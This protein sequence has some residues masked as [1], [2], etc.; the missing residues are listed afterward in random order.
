MELEHVFNGRYRVDSRLGTGGMAIVYC[1]TDL[2]LRRR[3]AIKVLRDQFSADDD[4]IKRFSY[5]AQAAAR[6]SHPNV[7][8]VYDFGH[9]GDAYF[10]VMELVEGE[11]LA[12]MLRGERRIPESVAIDYAT[13]IAAGLAFAHRQGLLHRDV[14]PAN[15][16]VTGDDV[17]KLGDF[18]IARAVAENAIGVTQPGMVMGSVAYVSPEQAQGRE[19]DARSD[20]YSLGVVLYQ[21]VTGR[22]P[23]NGETPVAVAL[24]HVSEAAPALDPA[25]DGV[26]PALASIVATLLQKNPDDRFASATELSSALREAREQPAVTLGTAGRG[27]GDAPTSRF[28][29]VTPPPAP[30]PRQSAAPDR[31]PSNGVAAF[32][33]PMPPAFDRRWIPF[34]ALMLIV[35]G[36]VGYLGARAL[37]PRKDIPVA[38]FVNN[39]SMQAQQSLVGDGLRPDVRTEA[40]ETVPLDRVIR[41]DPPVGS[42]TSR[43]ATVV[44]FV[45]SG[46]PLVPIPD[47]KGFTAADAQHMLAGTKF[48]T[49]IEGRFDATAAKDTV[50]DVSPAAGT[51]AAEGSTITLTVSQ[52][53]QPVRVPQLVGAA[54]DA[55]RA[56]LAPLGLKLNVDQQTPSD[57]I[58]SG[59]IISQAQTGGSSV[60]PGSTIGV[61]V[62]T[63]PVLV[64][65]P[66]VGAKS[67]ADAVATLQA[68]GFNARIQY[69]V[70]ATNAGGNVASQD[71]AANATAPRRSA[72]TI[73]VSVPGT[74]PDVTNMTLDAAK[75]AI[76]AGGYTVGNVAV[77]Q[78]GPTGKVARTEPEANA[79]LRPGEAVTIYYHGVAP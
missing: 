30:P 53:R 57:L 40:S 70:D 41:Q 45:S 79:A 1:G 2:L 31:P 75:T 3:V 19:L 37:G 50:L 64:S 55:A 61:T 51:S 65:V 35:A 27:S 76:V 8:N 11:T 15:I 52:G 7:V 78:D 54:V 23:F 44:L 39:S 68:A 71:P 16:L 46:P 6:L 4:F 58:P 47:V 42:M 18:G 56:Q 17:V 62:S 29:A 25:R 32:D 63:G 34:F 59:T 72:V 21:M 9:E 28:R 24:K 66:D 60:D 48:K 69:I 33:E 13:Q 74:V 49:K 26:S 20:L 22:L 36:V 73:S 67:M 43:G 12:A 38:N 14:K 5:E 10:I 77:T